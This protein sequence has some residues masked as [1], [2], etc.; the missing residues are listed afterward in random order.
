[1]PRFRHL[2]VTAGRRCREREVLGQ[3]R[4]SPVPLLPGAEHRGGV[5]RDDD[6]HRQLGDVEKAAAERR[7]AGIVPDDRL[8]GGAPQADEHLGADERELGLQPVHARQ[9][10]GP[11]GRVV[12]PA[13]PLRA[14]LEVLHGVRE[15]GVPLPHADLGENLAQESPRRAYERLA[16]AVLDVAGLLADEHEARRGRPLTE[17]DLGRVAPE[18]APAAGIRLSTL[19]AELPR[20]RR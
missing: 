20:G 12:D 3:L 19:L 4:A 16:A 2:A 6:G 10:L 15:V 11:V 17:D 5:E 18:I 1:M 13:R 14:P 8:G 9:D 7:D